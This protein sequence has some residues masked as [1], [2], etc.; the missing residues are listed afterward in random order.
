MRWLHSGKSLQLTKDGGVLLV[1]RL[2]V[3]PNHGAEIVVVHPLLVR[4]HELAP[5][6]LAGL[7]LHLV[8]VDRS[9]GIE[10][11]ESLLEVLVDFIIDLSQSETGALDS[12]ENGPVCLHVLDDFKCVSFGTEGHRVGAQANL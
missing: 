6:L 1:L 8:L 10:F 3:V 5:P 2:R 7:A 11:G 12:F 9:G 4:H